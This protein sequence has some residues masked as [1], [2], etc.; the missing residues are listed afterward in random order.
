MKPSLKTK[1]GHY[2]KD[3]YLPLFLVLHLHVAFGRIVR[4][5]EAE[6][7]GLN[8]LVYCFVELKDVNT[9]LAA[10]AG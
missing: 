10:R 3:S 9:A 5:G 6:L 7:T 8:A 1:K 4:V 2:K